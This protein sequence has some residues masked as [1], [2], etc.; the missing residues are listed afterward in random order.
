MRRS[1]RSTAATSPAPL[2][3]AIRPPSGSC[4][5]TAPAWFRRSSVT[6]ARRITASP[7]GDGLP[8][9]GPNPNAAAAASENGPS[10]GMRTDTPM[11]TL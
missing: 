4:L 8:V 1:C 5:I 10:T 11:A 9:F 2:T 7:P 6:K 3:S